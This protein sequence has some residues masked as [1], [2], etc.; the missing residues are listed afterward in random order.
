MACVVLLGVA[1]AAR[2]GAQDAE[3]PQPEKLL[4]LSL[5][6]VTWRDLDEH[7]LPA[8]EG[9]LADSSLADLAPRGVKPRALP[10]AAY[11]TISAGTRAISE[12]SVD[13]QEL[14]TGEES[15]G[16]TAG[17]IFHR[18]TGTQ[19]DGEYVALA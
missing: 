17:E 13:G 10:G 4:L 9:L 18:R 16:S 15:G 2:A 8:I 5:P 6:G 14:A 3:P 1:P 19:P 12:P 7:D 11:L